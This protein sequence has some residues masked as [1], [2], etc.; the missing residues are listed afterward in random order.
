MDVFRLMQQIQCASCGIEDIACQQF[1]IGGGADR[2]QCQFVLACIK[3]IRRR[4]VDVVPHALMLPLVRQAAEIQAGTHLLVEG[5]D[6][7][8]IA[9]RFQESE[10]ERQVIALEG[11]GGLDQFD[12]WRQR[13]AAM[14]GLQCIQ[15]GFRLAGEHGHDAAPG[16][17][18]QDIRVPRQALQRDAI[19]PAHVLAEIAEVVMRWLR[20]AQQADQHI[21]IIAE[22]RV[23]DSFVHQA[24]TFEPIHGAPVQLL[25]V[26]VR[27]GQPLLQ[28]FGEQRV[29]AI[30]L[31]AV[32][33]VH[34][35]DEQVA[36]LDGCNQFRRVVRL[37]DVPRHVD[38]ETA[39]DGDFLQE[40][41]QRAR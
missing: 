32:F 38:I 37:R 19:Q 28:K 35:Q 26:E 15:P 6:E 25:H 1:S 33:H 36:R 17:L 27:T 11:D 16:T 12:M 9:Q 2:Q 30:P 39:Q 18:Q 29:K 34:R 10:G 14:V 41:D 31:V 23:A 4:V 22:Y 21:E 24:G 40:I 13:G 5:M 3:R 8:M 7:D 20:P